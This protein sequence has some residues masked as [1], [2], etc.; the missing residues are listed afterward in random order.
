[1][2]KNLCQKN[3]FAFG[4]GMDRCFNK[5]LIFKIYPMVEV[6]KT[7]IND[8]AHAEQLLNEFRKQHF[9]CQ[10]HFD[11]QDCDN[12]FRVESD[13]DIKADDVISVFKRLGFFAELLSD[14]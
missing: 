9:A 7:N 3:L 11:L 5:E 8:D 14:N 4:K 13:Y 10:A 2:I 12:I 6:F 1:M